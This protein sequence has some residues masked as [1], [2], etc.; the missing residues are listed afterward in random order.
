MGKPTVMIDANGTRT[1]LAYH[2][3]GWL[4]K[5]TV[6][7]PSGDASKNAVTT[8][9]HDAVGQVTSITTPDGQTLH[10]EY[11]DARRLTA[12]S[13]STGRIEYTLDNASNITQE[14]VF[15][16]QNRVKYQLTKVYDELSRVMDV[17]SANEQTTH[18]GYTVNNEVANEKNP[19]GFAHQILVLE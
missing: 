5:V 8:M 19:R 14:Q 9:E 18:Y 17:V 2:S 4:E 15:D 3:R 11:D 6:V 1:E 13:N 16:A 12:I 10:Y 7:H